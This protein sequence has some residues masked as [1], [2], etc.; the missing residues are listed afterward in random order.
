MNKTDLA[1]SLAKK[2]ELPVSKSNEVINH[3]LE[4]MTKALVKNDT[5]QLVGFGSFSVKKRKPREG[6]NPR[7][8]EIIKI[9]ARKAIGFS[10]GK[11]LKDA[12]NKK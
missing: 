4:L 10:V 9:P 8:G 12:I 1:Q 2:F 6:R 5:I 3:I 11:A 7:S